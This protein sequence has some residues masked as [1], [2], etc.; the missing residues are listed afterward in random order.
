MGTGENSLSPAAI[1]RGLETRFIGQRVIYHPR[2]TSTME[3]ARQEAR[4]GAAEGTAVVAGE[5]TG[6][7]GRLGRLWLSP[8]GNVA[9]S[10]ILYPDLSHLPSLIM[11]ASLAVVHSIEAVTGLKA[12][13]S[14]PNDVLIDGKKVCGI[15]VESDVRRGT[16]AYAVIG[17]GI[18]VNLKISDFPEIPSSATSLSNELGSEVS[19]TGMIRQLFVDIERLY[20]DLQA[21]GSLYQEWR[22]SLVT[23]GRKVVASSGDISY[24][25]IAESVDEDGGL[26]LR[27]SDGSLIKIIAADVTLHG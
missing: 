14:W 21:G 25:G 3:A 22:G 12:Q 13:I 7:R 17:I 11:L 4:Q 18:N 27:R 2:L 20:L 16:V 9:L 1:T 24:E 26:L 8:E 5:Q 15:L 6:G 19:L 10:V 23:L